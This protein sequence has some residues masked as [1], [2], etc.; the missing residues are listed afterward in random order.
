MEITS[1]QIKYFKKG[2]FDA[3]CNEGVKHTKVLPY[4]SVVQSVEGNYD[5]ALGNR[6]MLQTSD[7]GFFIAPSNIRQTIVHHVN[8]KS[9]KMSAR[10]IFVEIIINKTFSLDSL[11]QFP[12]VI[13]EELKSELNQLFDRIF[14]TDDI[15]QNYSDCY[16]LMGRLLKA[17][18]PTPAH[19][20]SGV[21]AAVAYI[22]ENYRSE[23]TINALANIAK[24]SESN[25]YAVFK[26]QMSISPIAYLN[27]Y[28]LSIA[29]DR[30]TDTSDTASE[31]SY[32]VGIGDPLYFSKLFKKT[33]G[34][35]PKEYRSMY[36]KKQ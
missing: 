8:K 17:A 12:T 6:D 13:N 20:H 16:A 11:Y 33:Y 4:L 9:E 30:L 29:A 23:I 15:W 18:T 28:R 1:A 10:W 22:N 26:K 24:M 35:T 2:R 32:S 14:A 34:I 31:I 21:Q 25:F 36:R 3:V 7:G 5:I 27:N 19:I